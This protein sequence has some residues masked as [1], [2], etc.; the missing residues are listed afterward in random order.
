MIVDTA[1]LVRGVAT[2][3]PPLRACAPRID[4]IQRLLSLLTRLQAGEE[5]EGKVLAAE[6]GISR[7]TLFRDLQLL[8]I[9][10]IP[11][12]HD[13]SQSTYRL[14]KGYFFPPVGLEPE[15]AWSLLL[16]TRTV[17]PGSSHPDPAA[18]AQATRKIVVSLP[19]DLRD[20]CLRDL[21]HLEYHPH[22]S[23]DGRRVHTLI[24]TLCRACTRHEQVY[25]AYEDDDGQLRRITLRPFKVAFLH[26]EW[27]VAGA[28]V[29]A[30]ATTLLKL[31]RIAAIG[32]TK[33]QFAARK[34][35]RLTACLG[36]AW[37]HHP[38]G[39]VYRVVLHFHPTAAEEVESICWHESQ[40]T[41]RDPDGSVRFEAEVD[42]LG[43]IVRWIL[44]FA[45]RV[46]VVDPPELFRR[47]T[48]AARR[49]LANHLS[50]PGDQVPSRVQQKVQGQTGR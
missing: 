37:R 6:L 33:E 2:R 36:Q 50:A 44:G 47:V 17:Q 29:G 13:K 3:R 22:P 30:K 31:D 21:S 24:R 46:V 42:G 38:E 1:R 40:R 28:V 5:C 18:L 4:R 26:T 14:D 48:R 20:S 41:T 16:L 11:L 12:S 19:R 8:R 23:A 7:R 45:G 43:E 15:E 39:K 9:A 32:R 25:L 49:I 10:G 34:P 27:F 35:F